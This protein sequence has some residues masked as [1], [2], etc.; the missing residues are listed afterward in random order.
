MPKLDA[1]SEQNNG[2]IVTK[3]KDIV[4]HNDAFLMVPKNLLINVKDT[5]E[6]KRLKSVLLQHPEAF[7]EGKDNY[8]E[9]Y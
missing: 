4:N 5:I 7:S 9:S 6:N 1:P 8:A 2:E 3:C